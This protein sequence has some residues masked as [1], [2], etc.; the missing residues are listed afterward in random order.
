MV[1]VVRAAVLAAPGRFEVR[2]FP[3]PSIEAG[4]EEGLLRVERSGI[5]GTD[6]ATYFDETDRAPLIPGHETL[7][8]IEEIGQ[9]AA[10]RWS[11]QRGDRVILENLTPCGH[12]DTC[13]TGNYCFCPNEGVRYGFTPLS[14]APGLWGG[15]AEYVYLRPNTIIHKV[16]KDTPADVLATFNAIGEGLAWTCTSGQVGVGDTVLILGPGQKGIGCAI[17]AKVAGAGTVIMA[18]LDRDARKM[19]LARQ[20]GSDYTINV[21]REDTVQ[22]V[23][24]ITGQ[25][26][27]DLAIDVTPGAIQPLR[28]AIA[29]V[30]RGGRVVVGGTKHSSLDLDPRIVMTKTLTF[31]WAA[32]SAEY[33]QAIQIIESGRFPLANLH[34]HTFGLVS[35]GRAI[36]TLAG[37]TRGE[38]AVFVNID[39]WLVDSAA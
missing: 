27:A 5:C 9:E 28:D 38:E 18:G 6:V 24:E 34:S 36:E 1:D 14:R 32:W 13:R 20:F 2:S 30:R 3:R 25:R 33:R 16:T 17:A 19:E 29:S 21:E 8:I 11:V 37:L 15:F 35:V 12:C 23:R 4:A 22:R 39:P 7:G 31:P 26:L 10:R